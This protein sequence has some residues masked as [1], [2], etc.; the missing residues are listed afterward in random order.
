MAGNRTQGSDTNRWS[1][2]K[3]ACR[4]FSFPVRDGNSPDAFQRSGMDTLMKVVAAVSER[5]SAPGGRS[6]KRL[7]ATTQR[8]RRLMRGLGRWMQTRSSLRSAGEL[9]R[10]S[11]NAFEPSPLHFWTEG[12][13]KGSSTQH[14]RP[15][16]EPIYHLNFK[17]VQDLPFQSTSRCPL[18]LLGLRSQE[19]PVRLPEPYPKAALLP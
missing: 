10:A 17:D 6:P 8:S 5:S 19:Y 18:Q 13:D 2:E 11:G 1:T 4:L 9:D 3:C 16:L 15:N 14:F 7:E 12:S